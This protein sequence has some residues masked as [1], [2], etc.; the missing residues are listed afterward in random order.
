MGITVH[1]CGSIADLD[2]VEEF[3]DRVLDLA[4]EVGGLAHLWR[5]SGDDDPTRVVRGLSV[6]LAPGQET[7]SL[8]VSPEGWL[9][10]LFEIEAAENGTLKEPP[11]CFIKTQFGSVE[12]H[13]ALVELFA[14]LKSEFFPDLE[15]SDE[16]GYWEHRDAAMLTRKFLQ[17]QAAIDALAEG[18]RQT[19]LSAEAAED[20]QIVAARVERVARQV[21]ETMARPPEHP[22]VR[23]GDDVFHD[24]DDVSEAE[25]DA[26]YKENRRKQER[27]HRAIEEHIQRGEDPDDAFD[28]ALRDE[29]I[30]DLPGDEPEFGF[31]AD[32]DL[33]DEEP[34]DESW[35]ESLADPLD[36]HDAIDTEQHPLP[37]RAMDLSLQLRNLLKEGNEQAGYIDALMG[38][39]G[40]LMG[41]LAQAFCP[42]LTDGV[43]R[44]LALVQLKRALRGAA[45]VKGALFPLR[46]TGRLSERD[47]AE[48]R[49][50]IEGLET[51]ILAELARVRSARE[52]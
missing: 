33:C 20:P 52:S 13:V 29:G 7:L 18:L 23:F 15:V 10:P 6:N 47:L 34:E 9:V 51:A 25:W 37:K 40:D 19:S 1:Y 27:M 26:S 39:A 4:L 3:E 31:D 41:G 17:N 12:S 38:G 50:T 43:G 11:W 8:L 28:G 44:G 32:A 16:S 21:R 46:Q 45:F 24:W 35:K 49:A 48:L 36:E 30:I 22:P 42:G 5:S 14:A 2:R